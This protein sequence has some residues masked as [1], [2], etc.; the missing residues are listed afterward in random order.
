[1]PTPDK[2]TADT[3]DGE[4]FDKAIEAWNSQTSWDYSS[5]GLDAACWAFHERMTAWRPIDTAPHGVDV[6]LWCPVAGQSP[7]VM[8]VGQASWGW[9]NEIASNMSYHG[10]ATHW[11]PLPNARE[12]ESN[13]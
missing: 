11:Q 4:A 8:E 12:A 1:M 5:D 7:A 13:D 6:L 2:S 9:R 3:T 10:R